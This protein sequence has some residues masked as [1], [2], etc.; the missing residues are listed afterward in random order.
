MKIRIFWM[1]AVS[2]AI[3]SVANAKSYVPLMSQSG[4]HALVQ[5]VF[6]QTK[7]E[8]RPY[9]PGIRP[10]ELE[11]LEDAL[12][13]KMPIAIGN[14]RE[15]A[16]ASIIRNALRDPVKRA[17]LRG[18]YAEAIFLKKNP[19][20]GYVA[21]SN[22][23]KNDVYTWIPGQRRPFT[24][25]IKTHAS[26][27][28]ATYS[29]DMDKDE[30]GLFLIPDE[31]VPSLREY[32]NKELHEHELA[33]RTSEAEFVRVK[34]ERVRGT[35]DTIKN[36]DKDIS[37]AA[38]F[39]FQ[40]QYSGY[41]SLGASTAMVIGPDLWNWWLTGSINDQLMLRMAHAAS[42]SASGQA[43]SYP[44]SRNTASTLPKERASTSALS[45][46]GSLPLRGS[47]KG[48]ATISLVMLTTD[49]VFSA[50]ERAGFYR[51][52]QNE[53]FYTDLGGSIGGLALGGEAGA[54][55]G[56]EVTV[57]TRNPIY[58]GAAGF[59]T[60]A[61]VGTAGSIGGKVITRRILEAVNPE[62]LQ[63]VEST[64]V[65]DAQKRIKNS[66]TNPTQI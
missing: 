53:N 33:G 66:L 30:Y 15:K 47:V 20:W 11:L 65:A 29:K 26:G 64:A 58:G 46:L 21:K 19:N 52:M 59:I 54:F 2:V 45:K 32:L 39:A 37:R 3:S 36:Y 5:G 28:P 12:R 31:H 27:D 44:L 40:E 8:S 1:F 49:T 4:S 18:I 56:E 50:Y 24:A 25:Q 10:V 13:R 61:V 62:F 55:V 60:F 17:H 14:S 6:L 38:R 23:P 41:I 16:Q 43:A 42:I 51:A 63:K 57:A 34:L 48:N 9:L 35:G 7:A 22:A